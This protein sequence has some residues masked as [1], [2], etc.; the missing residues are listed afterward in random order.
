M[1][2]NPLSA[3][4]LTWQQYRPQHGPRRAWHTLLLAH[5]LGALPWLVSV[6]RDVMIYRLHPAGAERSISRASFVRQFR[7]LR[8]RVRAADVNDAT[9]HPHSS[10]AN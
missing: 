10:R 5:K 3:W 1:I 2:T 6:E 4:M 9:N 8:A 7:R